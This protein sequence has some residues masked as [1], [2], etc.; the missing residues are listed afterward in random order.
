MNS[1]E[2]ILCFK[3]I[4]DFTTELG[5]LFSKKQHSLQLYCRL[6][7]KTTIVHDESIKRHVNAFRIYC[8]NNREAI[9]NKDA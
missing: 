4:S 6:I 3:A 5:E 2:I 7:S 8:N 1:D 9:M